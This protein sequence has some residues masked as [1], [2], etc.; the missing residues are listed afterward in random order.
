MARACDRE[1][2]L[3]MQCSCPRP[4]SSASLVTP[5]AELDAERKALF[6]QQKKDAKA[7]EAQ[8]VAEDGMDVGGAKSGT[9]SANYAQASAGLR[10]NA[11]EKAKE[12]AKPIGDRG[13]RVGE[14][15]AAKK[16]IC[17]RLL[18]KNSSVRKALKDLDDD[19]SGSISRDGSLGAAHALGYTMSSFFIWCE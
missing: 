1:A 8:Y 11:R 16:I 3:L 5:R 9:L 15:N 19:G 17:D 18:E 14:V 4:A 13:A 12:D 7:A 6:E 10:A 2:R